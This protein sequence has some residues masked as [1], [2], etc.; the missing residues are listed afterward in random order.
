MES[1]SQISRRTFLQAT[2]AGQAGLK[3]SPAQEEGAKVEHGIRPELVV[4]GGRYRVQFDEGGNVRRISFLDQVFVPPLQYSP[5]EL[6]GELADAERL[7]GSQ[8]LSFKLKAAK[9]NATLTVHTDPEVRFRITADKKDNLKEAGL[10]LTFPAA[11][12]FHLAEYLHTGRQLDSDMPVGESY[13][14]QLEFN[15]LLVQHTGMWIRFRTG[16]KK[17]FKKAHCHIARHP[18]MFTMT[19]T[20]PAETHL[21]LAVFSSLDE[22]L[23][24]YDKWLETE[25]GVRKLTERQSDPAWVSD[26]KLVITV[27]MMRSNWEIAHD[28]SDLLN[29]AKEIREIGDAKSILF[30]IPGWQGA[31]DSNH[32]TYLPHPDL[33]GDKKFRE[34]T[35]YLHQNGFRLMIHTTGWGIDPYHP[36]IDTLERLAVRKDGQ[37]MGW[38]LG[39]SVGPKASLKFR[40]PQISLRQSATKGDFSIRIDPVPER[41][42]ALFTLG[43]VKTR[44]ARIRLTVGRRTI[45]TPAGWFESHNE[46]DFPFPL[47]LQ[48]GENSVHVSTT[49]E[50]EVDWSRSWYRIR[51]SFG[52]ETPYTTES[53]PILMADMSNPEYIRIYTDNVRSVVRQYGIDAVHVDATHHDVAEELLARLKEKLPGVAIACEGSETFQALGYWTFWQGGRQQSL[54]DYTEIARGESLGTQELF[55]DFCTC[56]DRGPSASKA[57]SEGA[58][59][60]LDKASPVCRFVREYIIPYPHL[61]AADAFVPIGKVCNHFPARLRPPDKEVLWKV[62]RDAKRLDYVPGLRVNYRQY[63]LDEE[64]KKAIKTLV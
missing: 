32:P 23:E 2:L 10:V 49:G 14:G 25:I 1:K 52:P 18:E 50:S 38:Q 9:L 64:T 62:L 54:T 56:G 8:E 37:F 21:G 43:G 29:L 60:W 7:T 19:F 59:A 20:W 15:F 42:E 6:D 28:F 26:I 31:Y 51:Y 16:E 39:Y 12:V 58:Y 47:A 34:L 30:Y 11:A 41:C 4:D 24:D 48:P 57:A 61:C 5:Y 36:N 46:Y 55:V 27:D 17:W 35:D 33:G 22:A 45:S 13:T 44:E 53:Y 3:L 63:G 40:T